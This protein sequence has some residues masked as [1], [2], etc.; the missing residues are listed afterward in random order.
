MPNFDINTAIFAGKYAFATGAG[1]NLISLSASNVLQLSSGNP[2]Q[3]VAAQWF[4][5]YGTLDQGFVL[6]GPNWNYVS[7]NNG[8]VAGSTRDDLGLSVFHFQIIDPETVYLIETANG[9]DYYLNVN[10]TTLERIT[11]TSVPLPSTAIF[12]QEVVTDSLNR[13]IQQRS[14]LA[15]PLTGVYL[16]GQDLQEIAFMGS[17][18]SFADFTATKLG[19]TNFSGCTADH[20][21][22]DQANME[23]WIAPGLTFTNCS[24]IKANMQ[25]VQLTQSVMNGCVFNLAQFA[26]VGST[27]IGY[28][29][30]QRADFTNASMVG[31]KFG[32]ALVNGAIFKGAT[33][34]NTDFSDAR[35]VEDHLDFRD[36]ILIGADLTG[37]DLTL[38]QISGD[39]NFM[40]A[41]LGGCNFTGHDLRGIVFAKAYMQKVK[42]DNTQLD[43][44]QLAYADLSHATLTG[45]ISMVGANLSNA[46]LQAAQLPGAQLGANRTMGT[47]LI[48]D[49]PTLDSGTLP[50]DAQNPPLSIPATATV[51]IVQPGSRWQIIEGEKKYNVTNNNTNLLVQVVS[52]V[53]NAAVLSNAYMVDANL[54]QANL[55]A[56]GMSGVHWYGGGANAESADLSL[57]NLSNANLSGMTFKQ[58]LMQGSIF[59]FSKLIGTQFNGAILGGSADLKATSFAFS[60]LQSTVF[61]ESNLFSADL[62]NAAF[63][64]DAGVNLFSIN[65]SFITTLNN[66]LISAELV[67]AFATANFPLFNAATI[68][69]NTPG[70]QWTICNINPIDP[71]QTGYY[72]FSLILVEPTGAAS[73]IQI[74][75]ISPG[76]PLFTIDVSTDSSIVTDLNAQNV[77]T[78]IQNAFTNVAYPL[79]SGASI[80]IGLLSKQWNINNIDSGND[81][82]TGYGNFTLTL[83]TP[84]NGLNFLQVYGAPP[85]L[86]ME[87]DSNRQLEQIK[88]SFGQTA[89]TLKQMDDDTTCPSGMK[90]KYL[91]NH[92]TYNEL[93]TAVLPPTPP[94]CSNCWG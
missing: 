87:I 81:E 92:L 16:V 5:L 17:D 89:I 9:V 10:G 15:N 63:A 14:T 50:T 85:L 18:L 68:A 34:T 52:N 24:F 60:S 19:K 29:N 4:N 27:S 26:P 22:F 65:N 80:Q 59:D 69:V 73:Y 90:L 84:S 53:G 37:H 44:A 82:Q 32:N 62:T 33:L 56:V 39:T 8:Y 66:A 13:M 70:K 72:Y 45:G 77:S 20:T 25:F 1:S 94:S 79:I 41:K 67:G 49:I 2:T 61:L 6:Q 88:M 58:S 36:A 64:L 35:G 55:Y 91:H 75:G 21:A 76:V 54:K 43:G 71:N 46:I 3:P 11:K 31:C 28:T 93:M 7:W 83:E 86:I 51:K 74:S 47:L 40:G 23:G 48:A 42:L 38:C 78:A 12:Q 57:A 30:L